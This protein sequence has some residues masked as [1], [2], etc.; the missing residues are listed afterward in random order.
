MHQSQDVGKVLA[1]MLAQEGHQRSEL[2]EQELPQSIVAASHH[3]KQH[4][5]DLPGAH[6]LRI[7]SQNGNNSYRSAIQ[8][9]LVSI[10]AVT[11]AAMLVVA[12]KVHGVQGIIT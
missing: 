1:N 5:H 10:A 7:C 9:H 11:V 2:L 8:I 6:P 3:P 12:T 4:W